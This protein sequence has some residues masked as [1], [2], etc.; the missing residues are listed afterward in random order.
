[1][2]PSLD[3]QWNTWSPTHPGAFVHLPTG[4]CLRV[5]V[6]SASDGRYCDLRAGQITMHE[7]TITGDYVRFGARV[8]GTDL[9]VEFAKADPLAVVGRVRIV[10]PGEWG[11]RF[12]IAL[13]IGFVDVRS[14]PEPWRGSEPSVNLME[15]PADAR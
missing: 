8:A 12:W 1:V 6:F 2:T 3:R 11:M 15:L 10:S 7:H 14:G 9:E 5:S 13:E 4:F